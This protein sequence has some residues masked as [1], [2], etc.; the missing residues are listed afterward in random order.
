MRS[1]RRATHAPKKAQPAD[2]ERMLSDTDEFPPPLRSLPMSGQLRP[3]PNTHWARPE[4]ATMK[5]LPGA[6]GAAGSFVANE[7]IKEREPV[8]ILVRNRAKAK[9]FEGVPT[10]EIVEG[11]MA[12][13]RSLGP[14]LDGVERTLMISSPDTAMAETQRRFIEACK[15]A[16]VQHVIKFSGLDARPETSFLFG[17]MHFE[18]ESYLEG[19]GLAWTLLRPSG[20]M[21][22]YLSEAPTVIGDGALYLALADT[23][24]NPIDLADVGKVGFRL[25][26]DGGHEGE[27]LAMTGPEALTMTEV[28]DRISTAIGKRVRY[29][30]VSREIRRQALVANGLP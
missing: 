26:R 21:Q 29:V 28:A 7:F 8:R 4:D 25:L 24:L 12:D 20:F 11:D 27:R 16:G 18:I 9:S 19:S 23:K 13:E 10:V 5:L 2:D 30:P 14:A 3:F 22:G 17:R 6:T 1:T 15:A